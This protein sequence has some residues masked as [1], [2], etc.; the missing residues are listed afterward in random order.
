M[1]WK[2]FSVHQSTH[3]H[4][5]IKQK[6]VWHMDSKISLFFR[7]GIGWRRIGRGRLHPK[8]WRLPILRPICWL[9]AKLRPVLLP[10]LRWLLNAVLWT[11]GLVVV[12]ANNSHRCTCRRKTF[13]LSVANIGFWTFVFYGNAN[14]LPT[15]MSQLNNYW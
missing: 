15:M 13:D 10:I 5:H 7:R 12:C 3:I 14:S 11:H 6:F 9:C 4:L 1:A 8:W 2:D